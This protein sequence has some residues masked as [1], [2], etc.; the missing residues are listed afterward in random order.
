[1]S[2]RYIRITLPEG[3]EE[4]GSEFSALQERF[5]QVL[6]NYGLLKAGLGGDEPGG[7]SVVIPSTTATHILGDTIV[8]I[9]RGDLTLSS[10]NTSSDPGAILT[11]TVG[12][13]AFLLSKTTVFGT[14][15]DDQHAYVFR[16]EIEKNNLLQAS[17]G[18][19]S[20]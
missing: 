10:L 20:Y 19:V 5:E 4:E 15:A 7:R 12:E 8:E 9:S 3:V 18:Y 13:A 1:M 14:L 16:P 17:E 2:T 6:V 11:L